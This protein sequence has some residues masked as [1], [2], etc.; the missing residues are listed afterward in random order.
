MST[1]TLPRDNLVLQRFL[2]LFLFAGSIFFG[3]G[4]LA[5]SAKLASGDLRSVGMLVGTGLPAGLLVWLGMV[6]WSGRGI[7][8]WFIALFLIPTSLGP[9]ALAFSAKTWMESLMWA[10]GFAPMAMATLSVLRND[11]AT[12]EPKT[13][14]EL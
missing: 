12:P 4:T 7:P 9:L 11:P 1:A 6:L 10:V 8:R 13:I 5:A 2:A 14:D 3:M